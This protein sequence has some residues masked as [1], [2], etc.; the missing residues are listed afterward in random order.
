M[1]YNHI[2][3][4]P[5]CLLKEEEPKYDRILELCDKALE[6]CPSNVKALFRKG[7]SL[8]AIGDYDKALATLQKAS[9]GFTISI[10][11]FEETLFNKG[12]F[13]QV[14]KQKICRSTYSLQCHSLCY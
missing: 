4:S 9:P 13:G 12:A 7:T 8:Y 6:A 10:S 1:S 3:I 5:A 2:I 14:V 11:S